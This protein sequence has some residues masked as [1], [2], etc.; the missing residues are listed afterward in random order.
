MITEY[1]AVPAS[2]TT[3][4]LLA[5]LHE[6]AERYTRFIAQYVYALGASG[7]LVGVLPLRDLVLARP[8]ERLTTLMVPNP[9][10]IFADLTLPEVFEL[11]DRNHF[12]GIPVIDERT[13]ILGVLLRE[14]VNE[15]RVDQ[16]HADELKSRGIVGGEELRTMPLLTRTSR[17]LA[18]LSINVLLNIVAAS[19]IA[20]YQ[21]TLSAVIALAVL[22]SD[23]LR[24]ERL[25]R[26]S[27]RRRKPARAGTG[28]RA[29]VRA[30]SGLAQGARRRL[31]ERPG[32]RIPDRRRCV[33]VAG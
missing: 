7:E 28:C 13:Q 22:P 24:H 12:V 31:P 15:A 17:R 9:I 16:A 11:F 14:D 33:A 6:N 3:R 26:Q 30:I 23:H 8:E 1:V 19:V 21:D 32:T 25:F 10:S 29:S 27:G 2:W 20:L 4:E 18:W 5:H